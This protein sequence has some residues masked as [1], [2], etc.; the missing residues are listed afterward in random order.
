MREV[1]TDQKSP[2]NKAHYKTFVFLISLTFSRMAES[3]F[4][5]SQTW[6]K[7]MNSQLTV[8]G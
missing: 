8:I 6:L 2:S 1:A 5:H 7:A 4:P 3:F